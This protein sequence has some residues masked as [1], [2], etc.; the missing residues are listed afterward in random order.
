MFSSPGSLSVLLGCILFTLALLGLIY[1]V[2]LIRRDTPAQ[3]ITQI[4]SLGKWFMISVAPILTASIIN[5]GFREREQ[6]MRQMEF[7]DKYV[8]VITQSKGIEIRWRLTEYFASV[9]PNEEMRSGWVDYQKLL[10]PKYDEYQKIQL[11]KNSLMVKE[12]KTEKDLHN[13]KVYNHRQNL[14]NL[15]FQPIV[16]STLVEEEHWGMIISTDK[17]LKEA[18]FEL[19]EA[20]KKGFEGQIYKKS[21]YY[22]TVLGSFQSKRGATE[23]IEDV[24]SALTKK[25]VYT[26]DIKS[27]CPNPI[28]N[29]KCVECSGE[30]IP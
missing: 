24:Q 9:A 30:I 17:T 12:V 28:G 19:S 14:I 22:V 20:A 8:D 26:V 29:G 4:I 6:D 27:W 5:D 16:Q 25:G 1:T 18:Q 11:A 2:R 10:K 21:N 23:I 7:Y 3:Q 13:I 15:E